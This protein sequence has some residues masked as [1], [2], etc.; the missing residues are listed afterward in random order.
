[1]SEPLFKIGS[2]Y[3]NKIGAACRIIRES[4]GSAVL[5]T[6]EMK[7]PLGAGWSFVDGSNAQNQLSLIPGELHLVN[8][9]WEPVESLPIHITENG[10]AKVKASDVLAQP[11]VQHDLS[12]VERLRNAAMIARDGVAQQATTVALPTPPLT[13]AHPSIKGLTF[14]GA[15]G[16]RF[17]LG[18]AHGD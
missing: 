14:L 11:K 6:V 16:H 18:V 15:V 8:G 13:T 7:L 4:R 9:S 2:V 17:G 3:R 10:V 1:M 12:T 5:E